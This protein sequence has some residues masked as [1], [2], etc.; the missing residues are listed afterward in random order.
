MQYETRFPSSLTFTCGSTVTT[1]P[2]DYFPNYM[3]GDRAFPFPVDPPVVL[4]PGVT[5]TIEQFGSDSYNG[6]VIALKAL[7]GLVSPDHGCVCDY[8]REGTDCLGEWAGGGAACRVELQS[9]CTGQA[10][11]LAGRSSAVA[12]ACAG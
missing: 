11:W 1:V 7:N 6:A 8:L 12:T 10:R 3:S 9:S 4:R 5:C 2:I